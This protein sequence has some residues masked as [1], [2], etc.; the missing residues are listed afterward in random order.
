VKLLALFVGALAIGVM[1][2][3]GAGEGPAPAE[4]PQ[5]RMSA[6]EIAKLPPLKVEARHGPKPQRLVVHDL[7]EGA[8][9]VMKPGDAML[10]DW[11]EVPYGQAYE[12]APGP[13]EK[14]LEFA[15]GNFVEG[16][17]KGLPG[18]KVG[19]RREL[20]VPPRLGDT[21]V[22]MVYAVDLLGVKPG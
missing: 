14:Q 9:A 17:E 5:L 11:A 22:T 1:A 3:C 16:W 12:A 21:G 6:A 18:M 15:F 2:A 19:G 8:G 7:R 4:K 13:P 10:V 20:I